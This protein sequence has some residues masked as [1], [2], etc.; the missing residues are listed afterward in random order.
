MVTRKSHIAAVVAV[1]LLG[2][3]SGL[4]DDEADDQPQAAPPPP[5]SKPVLPAGQVSTGPSTGTVVG[6]R[7]QQIRGEF[8]GMQ[9]EL[10]AQ[11]NTL[12]TLR[13][14][15]I[16]NATAYTTTVGTINARLQV[17][18]TPGNPE[19]VAAWNNAQ[20]SLEKMNADLGQMNS[21]ASQV[22]TSSSKTAYLIDSV[23]ATYALQGAI[24]EDHRQLKV[25][26]N[27][28]NQTAVVVDRLL[29]ELTQDIAR[30][31]A[32]LAAE[33]NNLVTL[34]LAVKNG[35]LLG[36][37]LG[38]RNFTPV[39]GIAGGGPIGIA[40]RRPLMIVR[41]DQTRVQ[42]EQALY[43]AVS[44]VLQRRPEAQFDLVAVAPAAGADPALGSATS[45]RNAERILR[46]MTDMGVNPARVQM[47]STSSP[48]VTVSEVHIYVR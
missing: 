4:Y 12:R 39:S 40:G 37:S 17:G 14:Q 19:L 6:T 35:R 32:V 34:S 25:L 43:G 1:L 8:S 30:Q 10:S 38:N 13:S 48:Q 45:K 11:T 26:E 15:A 47:S 46:S 23:R 22:A 20:G 18:T 3:C 28:V 41:F 2:A 44:E 24:D 42:Y 36:P 31:S 9:G 21:L 5:V 7:V 16:Q 33:R 29:S 27:E